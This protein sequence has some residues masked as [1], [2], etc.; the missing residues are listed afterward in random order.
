MSLPFPDALQEFKVELG[1]TSAQNGLKSSGSVSLVTKSGTNGMHGDL[2][3]F[4]RNASFNAR[5]AFA[6]K[7]DTIKRNQFGGTAGGAIV[8]N[9]LFFFTGYQGT[10]I[11]QAPS[12]LTGIVPTAAMKAGDFTEFASAGCNGG[13]AVTLKAP[14]VNN[15]LDPS[16]ISKQAQ[17]FAAKLPQSSDPCGKILLGSPTLENDHMAIGR[18]DYQRS[19]SHS[20]FG[21][22]LLDSVNVP[23]PYDIDPTKNILIALDTG[24]TGLAQGFT[25]GE[26]YL[27]G[28]NIVNAFRFNAN[29]IA[30]AK[31]HSG[32]EAAAAGPRDVGIQTFADEP[33]RP[34]ATITGAL[35]NNGLGGLNGP[36]WGAT[37]TAD[38]AVSDDLSVLHGN[39]QM[40]FGV[41]IRAWWANSYSEAMGQPSFTFNGQFTGLGMGD[42]FAGHV[43]QFQISDATGQ[44]KAQ[45]Y[46]GVYGA[47]TWKVNSK[48][49]LNYGLRWEPYFPILNHDGGPLHFDVNALRQGIKTTQFTNAPPGVF[50]QGDP[51]FPGAAGIYKHWWEFSPRLGLAW[52]L[53]G[54]GRT[55]IRASGGTFYDYISS[56]GM[57][58]LVNGSPVVTPKVNLNDVGYDNPWANY[59]GGDPFPLAH[60]RSVSRNLPWA[61]YSSMLQMDYDTPNM[62]VGQWSLSLQRQVGTD[63]LVSTSYIGNTT[64]HLWS[65]RQ[66]NPS[67]FLG[68]G[69]CTI[70]GIQYSTC[71]TT[72]NR[73]QRRLLALQY[74]GVGQNFGFV[75]TVDSGGKANYNALMV[76]VER[77][78]AKGLIINSNY[79]WSHCISDPFSYSTNSGFQGQGWT[80]SYNRRYDRGNCETGTGL[81][82]GGAIDRHHIFNLSAVAEVPQFSNRTARALGSG[83]RIAPI[84]KILSGD[85]MSIVTTQ[86]R[87]LTA[88]TGFFA[89][90]QRVNQVLAS[91]YGDKTPGKYLNPAAFDLP[92]LGTLGNSGAGAVAGPGFWQFD[93]ALSRTFQVRETKKLEFRAEAFN[94]T[95]S[96]HLND[97][98]AV[99]PTGLF[100][101][102]TSAKD[103][104]IMQ[105]ALKYMF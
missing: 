75:S 79:T 38:F 30:A 5:N 86:D 70:N 81:N 36:I 85:Y 55:S 92:A 17:A 62:Q 84:F 24:K 53:G 19:A 99:F 23:P 18:V 82:E 14:F 45:R 77:R 13:R 43:D 1:A 3:E 72:A 60:G 27:F 31:T 94:V 28:A 67:V 52:N 8:A 6:A 65:L 63:W 9:K 76:A 104:R 83:W 41:Q 48:L 37:R 90:G 98:V 78:A 61:P 89:T 101:Q 21:R 95:N 32:Y 35:N 11:R 69:P 57:Q 73:D 103:P 7:R 15:R 58:G 34:A 20:I 80:D 59:P 93:A 56:Q 102:V 50:F 68:L 96:L 105:F 88:N 46:L 54:D 44:N 33:H 97:P 91:P 42:F 39:H 47:D 12:D 4:V 2:F 100:G 25:L 10:T 71:S 74:P 40:A 16:L 51:G 64:T 29:R 66:T 87:A 49:T 26:T 22:Y